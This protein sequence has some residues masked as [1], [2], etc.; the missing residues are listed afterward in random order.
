MSATFATTLVFAGFL[1]LCFRTAAMLRRLSFVLAI[2]LLVAR[3]SH[4]GL[5]L[6]LGQCLLQCLDVGFAAS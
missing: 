1:L 6:G 3:C 4:F 2:A 5:E